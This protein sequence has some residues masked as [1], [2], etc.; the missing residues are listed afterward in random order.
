MCGGTVCFL[1]A[2]EH[3]ELT[4]EHVVPGWVLNRFSLYDRLV[5]LPNGTF[6]P[7]RSYVVPCCLACNQLLSRELETPISEAFGEGIDGVEKFLTSGNGARLFT[8]LALIFIKMHYKDA[9][10]LLDR[11]RRSSTGS[12]AK[13]L[14][15]D[16]GEMHHAYC[17]ARSVFSKAALD[18][19]ALGSLAVFSILEEP[20]ERESFDLGDVTFANTFS[21]RLGGVGVIACFGDGGAVLYKLSQLFLKDICGRLAF[22]QFREL[23]AHFAC[24][25]LHLKNPPEFSTL[26][27][28]AGSEVSISCTKRDPEPEFYELDKGIFGGLME[29]IL[30]DSTKGMVDVPDYYNRLVKGDISFLFADDGEFINYEK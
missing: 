12:I 2:E 15:Y 23:V 9:F 25:R 6:L 17:L 1:C 26:L 8:W 21:I 3:E 18:S 30:Y 27:D 16:W 19:K 5:A 22:P 7:Y 11:D 24:C 14:E 13:E 4:R 28:G 20:E 29:R 10:L